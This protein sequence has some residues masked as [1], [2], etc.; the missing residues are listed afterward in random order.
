MPTHKAPAA[1][2]PRDWHD[3]VRTWSITLGIS[4]VLLALMYTAAITHY[5]LPHFGEHE[6]VIGE[7]LP[8]RVIGELSAES[9]IG[10]LARA[11]L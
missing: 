1:A 9:M 7:W 8:E 10:E 2:I 3:A 4:A 5:G 6:S 11:T